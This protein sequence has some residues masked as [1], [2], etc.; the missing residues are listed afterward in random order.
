[1]HSLLWGEGVAASA[2]DALSLDLRRM[3]AD[4]LV[5]GPIMPDRAG[6]SRI[7]GTRIASGIMGRHYG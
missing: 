3:L 7:V 4:G 5:G 6:E 2:L 1:M